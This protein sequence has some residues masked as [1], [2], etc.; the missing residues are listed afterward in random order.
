MRW[1]LMIAHIMLAAAAVSASSSPSVLAMKWDRRVL[2]V[3]APNEEDPALVEQRRAM[4]R[5]KASAEER[6]LTI[7]E[8]IGDKVIGASDPADTLRRRYRLPMNAFMVILIGKDG[9]AKLR[10]TRPIAAATLEIAI[11]AMPMRRSGRR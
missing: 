1:Q 9:D 11:D 6:D 7:V 8:I 10:Q 4:A 5:W 3:C 2:L